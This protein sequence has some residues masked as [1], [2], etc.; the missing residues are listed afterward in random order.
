MKVNIFKSRN[1]KR[2]SSIGKFVEY[3]GTSF[4]YRTEIRARKKIN[5]QH[6]Y[7]VCAGKK[8]RDVSPSVESSVKGVDDKMDINE[9]HHELR[10]GVHFAKRLQYFRNMLSDIPDM[11]GDGYR[12]YAQ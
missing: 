9:S 11:N 8:S 2:C 6:H 1:H 7:E 12:P 5:I 4:D 10:G 3:R